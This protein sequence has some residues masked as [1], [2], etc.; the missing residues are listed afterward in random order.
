MGGWGPN[1]TATL[2]IRAL[3]S[4]NLRR[5]IQRILMTLDCSTRYLCVSKFAYPINVGFQAELEITPGEI[6]N[7]T[8]SFPFHRVSCRRTTLH[9]PQANG[10]DI[11]SNMGVSRNRNGLSLFFSASC[12]I[13]VGGTSLSLESSQV[14]LAQ[15][16][17]LLHLQS[18]LN[19]I[20]FSVRDVLGGFT[21]ISR[22]VLYHASIL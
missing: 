5:G 17:H 21:E 15:S 13:A 19:G 18:C 16:R 1:V 3:K 10:S 2:L 8:L 20:L 11:T 9:I 14:I 7:L 6:R 22:G 4:L 12:V